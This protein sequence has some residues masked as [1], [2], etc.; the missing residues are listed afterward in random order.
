MIC[1]TRLTRSCVGGYSGSGSRRNH[2]LRIVLIHSATQC[3]AVGIEKYHSLE[4]WNVV[5]FVVSLMPQIVTAAYSELCLPCDQP[6]N[7][8]STPVGT[9]SVI[10]HTIYKLESY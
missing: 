7:V 8:V 2:P 6:A 3:A 10:R 4:R 9:G 5:R 1:V